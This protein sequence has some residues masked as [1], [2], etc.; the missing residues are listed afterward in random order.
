MTVHG[1]AGGVCSSPRRRVWVLLTTC[2]ALTCESRRYSHYVDGRL[3]RVRETDIPIPEGIPSSLTI[4]WSE[5][6]MYFQGSVDEV[7]MFT[8]VLSE[9][10]IHA[11][12]NRGLV[13]ALGLRPD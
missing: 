7:A 3:Q 1:H 11:I 13:T 10:E 6:D 8:R 2:L 4:G 12:M 5:S 9:D